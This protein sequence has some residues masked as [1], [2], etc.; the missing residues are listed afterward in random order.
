MNSIRIIKVVTIKC[1]D[2][3]LQK[4]KYLL[5]PFLHTLF[6]QSDSKYR[7]KITFCFRKILEKTDCLP[8]VL[9]PPQIFKIIMEEFTEKPSVEHLY[10][11]NSI[12]Y[13]DNKI[14]NHEDK[15]T[16]FL[17]YD[18]I[19]NQLIDNLQNQ[20][21]QKMTF[22][23]LA[24][25]TYVNNYCQFIISN[26]IYDPL[27]QII[28]KDDLPFNCRDDTYVFFC[29]LFIFSPSDVT[30]YPQFHQIFVI[31]TDIIDSIHSKSF[32]E[33]FIKMIDALDDFLQKSE[34]NLN[35]DIMQV[36]INCTDSNFPEIAQWA[37]SKMKTK[38]T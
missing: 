26:K 24:N 9:L 30:S 38:Q 35:I 3:L 37:Q 20:D 18:D 31:M 13:Y 16:F 22:R 10:L 8:S 33:C 19:F 14:E 34:L 1:K 6:F 5:V 32:T 28:L 7:R 12:L 2:D 15:D 23:L 17:K 29:N 27:F 25:F 11:F 21:F 4:S 36:Y